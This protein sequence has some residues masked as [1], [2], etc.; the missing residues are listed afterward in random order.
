[1]DVPF[2]ILLKN[3][4]ETNFEFYG[5]IF[6]KPHKKIKIQKMSEFYMY[7]VEIK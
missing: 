2:S 6:V 1:M 7:T 5:K 4:T 3:A